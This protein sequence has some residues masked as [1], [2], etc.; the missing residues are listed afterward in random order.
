[1][2]MVGLMLEEK[3]LFK[4]DQLGVRDSKLLTPEQR[5]KMFDKLLAL[6]SHKIVIISPQEIDEA[7]EVIEQAIKKC[8]HKGFKHHGPICAFADFGTSTT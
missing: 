8:K 6:G 2:A 3:D 5:E 4:L 7:L 1:M